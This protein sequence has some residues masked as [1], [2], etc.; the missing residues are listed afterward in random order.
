[1]RTPLQQ[2]GAL[3]PPCHVGH[4]GTGVGHPSSFESGPVLLIL[5]D[6]AGLAACPGKRFVQMT[7][8]LP[9]L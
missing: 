6:L 5:S 4:L 2:G 9:G 3:L 8:S 1:M 7:P